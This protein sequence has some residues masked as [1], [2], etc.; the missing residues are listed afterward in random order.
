MLCRF[1]IKQIIN[2]PTRITSS[3]KTLI[4][5]LIVSSE[6]KIS[7]SGVIQS[8]FSDHCIIFC[9]RKVVKNNKSVYNRVKIRSTKN[10]DKNIFIEKLSSLDWSELYLHRQVNAAWNI[11]KQKFINILNEVAPFK[12][13]RIKGRT[14]PWITPEILELIRERD[15]YFSKYN[16]KG[17]PIHYGNYCKLRN[18]TQREIKKAKEMYFENKIE[19]NKN[20]PKNLWQQMKNLGYSNKPKE[21][22]KI[23][24]EV[25]GDVCRSLS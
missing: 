21:S 12:D 1:S 3:S 9:T 16:K 2:V 7:Q 17:N 6:D 18:K 14:E 8:G 19:E 11:F 25:D 15:K 10:Y 22:S 13:I 23:V 24:I 20:N 5:H 4:D